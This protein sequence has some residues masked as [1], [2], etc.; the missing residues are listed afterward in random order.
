MDMV[1]V[2]EQQKNLKNFM[3]GQES[4]I[5]NLSEEAK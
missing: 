5:A 4:I 3:E 1:V 2:L